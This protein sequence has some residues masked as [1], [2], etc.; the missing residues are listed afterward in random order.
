MFEFV[1]PVSEQLKLPQ[2]A[3]NGGLRGEAGRAG[4]G[5]VVWGIPA[6]GWLGGSSLAPQPLSQ[7]EI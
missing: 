2:S 1:E 6:A 7:R 3:K 4:S 5:A